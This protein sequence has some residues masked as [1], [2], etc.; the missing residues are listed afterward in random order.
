MFACRTK[1]MGAGFFI[2]ASVSS[3]TRHWLCAFRVCL[4]GLGEAVYEALAGDRKDRILPTLN[5]GA[6]DAA[7]IVVVLQFLDP[8][9]IG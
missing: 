8:Q 1:A 6:Q 2:S 4:V 3:V 9:L 7:A 5:V